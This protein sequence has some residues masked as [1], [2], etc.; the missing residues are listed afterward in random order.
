MET[1]FTFGKIASEKNFT[2]REDETQQLID[3]FSSRTNTI[4]ISPRRWGKTSL[5]HK[6]AQIA[7]KKNKGVRFCFIDLYNVRT[8]E[9]FYQYLAEEVL[10]STSSKW[11][12]LIENSKRFFTQVIPK[13]TFS[14]KPYL[15]FSLG[16]D[17]EE[18]KRRP[19]EILNLPEN[20]AR[21][22]KIN[23]VVCIDEFQNISGFGDSVSIQKK[24]RSNWQ[25]HEN[26]SYCLYGSKR[27]MLTEVFTSQAMPFY[28]FGSILFLKKIDS[29]HLISFIVRRFKDTGKIISKEA[30]EKITEFAACHPYYTQ[31]IAQIAWLLCVKSC[32]PA[33]VDAAIEKLTQQLDFLFHSITDE[34]SNTQLNFLKALLLGHQQLSSKKIIDEFKLGTSANIAQIKKA[35]EKKEIV[36]LYENNISFL[37]PMYNYWLRKYYFKIP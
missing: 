6:A 21:E 7:A 36:D 3:N 28:K 26:V 10:K 1:P 25:L 32:T 14:P 33:T 18:V 27:H 20:I 22:K 16:F 37:D 31:Q 35:L 19:D 5:V 13:I 11:Q 29:H 24:L 23:L 2:D 17:W 15:E 12:E 30:A 8:E 4:L 9:Q 34:L